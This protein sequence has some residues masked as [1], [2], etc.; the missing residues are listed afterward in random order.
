MKE[1]CNTVSAQRSIL[2]PLRWPQAGVQK[3]EQILRIIADTVRWDE[4]EAL[5]RPVYQA[6]VR[7]TGRRG[8]SLRML[9]R[10]RV[11][12]I[13]WGM[14]DRVTEAAIL[15]SHS[16]AE[17]IGSD[18]WMPRP[19]SPTV[20]RAF[21][22]LLK[23]TTGPDGLD[24]LSWHLADQIRLCLAQEGLELRSGR[25]TEPAIRRTART[26]GNSG[27]KGNKCAEPSSGAA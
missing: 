7:K 3:R 13:L 18:P 20:L 16:M 25:I 5:V 19:P 24:S 9:L 10:C 21:R 17:F 26:D 2:V 15:D 12:Q 14:S 27:N 11:L 8:Y 22:N 1:A 4:L 23:S 6:D